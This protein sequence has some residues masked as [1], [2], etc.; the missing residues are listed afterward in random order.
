MVRYGAVRVG[1]VIDGKFITA[2]TFLNANSLST[3]YMQTANLPIRYEIEATGT[4]TG[5]ATLEQVCST[6]IIEGGYAPEGV[7]KMIGT[8]SIGGVNL[9]TAGTLYN[10]A[11][12]RIKSGRPY[13]VIVPS[14]F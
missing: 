14:R 5:S 4:L 11:T 1:F 8:A 10:L 12:I 9:T 13:A 7:T 6:A 3:V 2:H